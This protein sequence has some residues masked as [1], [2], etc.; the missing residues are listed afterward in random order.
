MVFPN[1]VVVDEFPGGF[2]ASRGSGVLPLFDAVGSGLV[3]AAKDF[4]RPMGAVFLRVW[5][6][7]E[8]RGDCRSW[9]VLGQGDGGEPPRQVRVDSSGVN[10]SGVRDGG[11]PA[12]GAGPVRGS[13]GRMPPARLNRPPLSFTPG[14]IS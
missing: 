9:G 12:P 7:I 11:H 14:F 1:P 6:G 4:H 3:E 5:G 2:V 8:A 10:E 13:G